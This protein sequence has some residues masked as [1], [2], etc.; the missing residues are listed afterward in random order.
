MLGSP[1]RNITIKQCLKRCAHKR[2][3]MYFFFT[4]K[5]MNNGACSKPVKRGDYSSNVCEKAQGT[6]IEESYEYPDDKKDYEDHGDYKDKPKGCCAFFKKCTKLGV[7]NHSG[8]TCIKG[9]LIQYI[10]FLRTKI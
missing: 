8:H 10:T 9:I 7:I 1:Q 2:K 5:C 3:C 6:G 4:E